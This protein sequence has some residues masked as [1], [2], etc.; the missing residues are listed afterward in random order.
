ML[1]RLY[2]TICFLQLWCEACSFSKML[3]HE[4]IHVCVLL[5]YIVIFLH[6]F[7]VK[8]TRN[9]IWRRLVQTRARELRYLTIVCT[10]TTP[11]KMKSEA[12]ISFVFSLS[13]W[14]SSKGNN[15]SMYNR[16]N[17]LIPCKLLTRFDSIWISTI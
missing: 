11:L 17:T 2:E 15:S 7:K 8:K 6:S 1:S 10:K 16:S 9:E 3:F 4:Q 13:N 14:F 5:D 12:P